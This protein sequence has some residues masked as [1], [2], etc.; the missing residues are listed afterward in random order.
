Q[1]ARARARQDARG[2][3]SQGVRPA[4]PDR[5]SPDRQP[6]RDE[7]AGMRSTTM[8]TQ[9]EKD[10]RTLDIITREVGLLE[11]QDGHVSADDKRW[12]EAVAAEMRTRI[13]EYRR[14]RLPK[15]IPPIKKAQPI[16]ERL[17]AMPRALLEALFE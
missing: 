16:S 17:V 12:A 4:S 15:T 2:H 7:E 14:D 5:A 11:M 9:H 10:S 8:K 6:A 13:A 1:G 3:V